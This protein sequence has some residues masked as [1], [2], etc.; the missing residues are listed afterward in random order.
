MLK[1][2]RTDIQALRAL[3]VLVVIGNHLELIPGGAIGL[4]I[5]FVISGFVNTES[6]IRNSRKTTSENLK[7]FYSNRIKRLT[8]VTSIAIFFTFLAS[9]YIFGIPYFRRYAAD[10]FLSNIMLSNLGFL[11]ER[12]DYR[13]PIAFSSPFIHFWTLAVAAQVYVVLPIIV[14]LFR[15]RYKYFL[16]ILFC[17]SLAS[18]FFLTNF[19]PLFSYYSPITRSWE[20]MAGMILST[21][22]VKISNQKFGKMLVAIG[23]GILLL[24]SIF[25]NESTATPSP[26]TIFPVFA[27]LIIIISNRECK[28]NKFVKL[29]NMSFAIYLVHWP[30]I[31][32]VQIFFPNNTLLYSLI[33]VV[34]SILVGGSLY[35][36]I[37]RRYIREKF[38]LKNLFIIISSSI[39]VCFLFTF[40]INTTNNQIKK[41][42]AF[43]QSSPIIYENGCHLG[44]G[45]RTVK[46]DGCAFGPDVRTKIAIVG[47]SHAAQWF[48]GFQYFSNKSGIGFYSLTKSGCPALITTSQNLKIKNLDC[49]EWQ[50]SLSSNIKKLNPRI[51]IISN[52]TQINYIFPE[53]FIKNYIV[54]LKEF[55]DD[56]GLPSDRIIYLLDT[57]F[58]GKNSIDC[59]N[60]HRNRPS[61]C[62]LKTASNSKE[63]ELKRFLTAN[64][65]LTLDPKDIMCHGNKCP[66]FENN[67]NIF[68]DGS[69]ISN[70]EAI[71][72]AKKGFFN[73]IEK[74]NKF[75]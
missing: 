40:V 46:I 21:H 43:D 26:M 68:R 49:K 32:L 3:A 28:F 39:A 65:I 33:S 8:P 55:I 72:L 52:L 4:D 71:N 36:F 35:T 22:S 6:L 47:D 13:Q 5:F 16:Y 59:L 60:F 44:K 20:I 7:E 11:Q 14:L 66:A 62:A 53:E 31:Q 50:L 24:C 51:L 2:Q 42:I 63:S 45:Q 9:V 41:S 23:L 37:E 38:R 34:I 12:Y 17:I 70:W 69:H 10:A 58:P 54:A 48:S 67:K 19:H 1:K 57:P 74:L 25:F 61:L 30:L 73:P 18:G 56:S 27:T 75:S 15:K 29:G 64:K